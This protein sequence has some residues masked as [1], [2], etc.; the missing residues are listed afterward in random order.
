MVRNDE[1]LVDGRVRRGERNRAAIVDALLGLLESGD[2]KPS[3][4]SIAEAAGVSVRSV[5]QHFDDLES[6]YATVVERQAERL[7]R[8]E[9]EIDPTTTF[10][11]RVSA[12]VSQRA[13]LYEH[14]TPVR[15]ATLR[16]A[17]ES[18]ALQDGLKRIATRH[19]RDVADLFAT[20]LDAARNATVLRAA[21]VVATS[22]ETWDRLRREQ[23]CSID[24][25]R[26]VVEQL[27]KGTVAVA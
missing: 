27:V 4:R 12:F 10:D 7:R 18:A 23:R 2:T 11:E 1:T 9:L 24:T 16:V 26:R 25:A 15:R 5:F 13:R 17:H 22:W 20:E 3:A 6:L 19:A 21:L 14:I 8:F